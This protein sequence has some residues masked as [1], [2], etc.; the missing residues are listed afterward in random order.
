VDFVE[1][2]RGT[3][4]AKLSKSFGDHLSVSVSA[5]NLTNVVN[6]VFVE[7]ADGRQPTEQYERGMS[8]SLGLTVRPWS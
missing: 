2:G 3:L 4:D 7:T 8:I 5:E 1:A 6:V